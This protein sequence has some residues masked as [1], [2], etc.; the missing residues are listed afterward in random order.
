MLSSRKV[1]IEVRLARFWPS[2]F[3]QHAGIRRYMDVRNMSFAIVRLVD[4]WS[5]G[6][7]EHPERVEKHPERAEL[8]NDALKPVEEMRRIL[9]LHPTCEKSK[10]KEE[11]DMVLDWVRNLSPELFRDPIVVDRLSD[12]LCAKWGNKE[13]LTVASSDFCNRLL[14]SVTYTKDATALVKFLKKSPNLGDKKQFLARQFEQWKAPSGTKIPEIVG[15]LHPLLATVAAKAEDLITLLHA[16]DKCKKERLNIEGEVESLF[17]ELLSKETPFEAVKLLTGC[18]FCTSHRLPKNECVEADETVW[19]GLHRDALVAESDMKSFDDDAFPAVGAESRELPGD[20]TLFQVF[21]KFGENLFAQF[22]RTA[23]PAQLVEV[24]C[25]SDVFWKLCRPLMTGWTLEGDCP[26]GQED[27]LVSIIEKCPELFDTLAP[28]VWAAPVDEVSTKRVT[29]LLQQHSANVLDVLPMTWWP[30]LNFSS[31]DEKKL[32]RVL[33]AGIEVQPKTVNF[34]K[35][36]SEVQ[37]LLLQQHWAS[38]EVL[39]DYAPQAVFNITACLQRFFELLTAKE[40]ELRELGDGIDD[41]ERL[42]SG[43]NKMVHRLLLAVRERIKEANFLHTDEQLVIFSG[44][45]GRL[46]NSNS[47]LL[48]DFME[49]KAVDS[50]HLER[51]VNLVLGSRKFANIT[52]DSA[53]RAMARLTPDER[54]ALHKRLL[55][56]TNTLPVQVIFSLSVSVLHKQSVPLVIKQLDT[57]SSDA[58]EELLGLIRDANPKVGNVHTFPRNL[59]ATFRERFLERYL[60]DAHSKRDQRLFK[61]FVACTDT[62]A[63]PGKIIEVLSRQLHPLDDLFIDALSFRASSEDVHLGIEV[64]NTPMSA[65]HFQDL[66]EFFAP[67]EWTS[68]LDWMLKRVND[69][70]EPHVLMEHLLNLLDNKAF[71]MVANKLLTMIIKWSGPKQLRGVL[72][73]DDRIRSS[74][75][76]AVAKRTTKTDRTLWIEFWQASWERGVPA[77]DQR[78]QEVISAIDLTRN[79]LKRQEVQDLGVDHHARKLLVEMAPDTA[80]PVHGFAIVK[81]EPGFAASLSDDQFKQ[82]CSVN[83]LDAKSDTRWPLFRTIIPQVEPDRGLTLAIDLLNASKEE[84]DVA[85]VKRCFQSADRFTRKQTKLQAKILPRLWQKYSKELQEKVI[86]ETWRATART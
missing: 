56:T 14:Q 31:L 4:R 60:Q 59:R 7:A 2:K 38:Y 29:R 69:S 21:G 37:E 36:D 84:K 5:F 50:L 45:E 49:S 11:W 64:Q 18:S 24:I 63:I 48:A 34:H 17:F 71:T 40:G 42:K 82:I 85:L 46:D 27:A 25:N 23:D 78:R 41:V 66:I 1:E 13:Q 3:V 28:K 47:S 77:K 20:R 35:L 10:T 62:D 51:V 57:L 39:A 26:A 68:R 67:E 79:P 22:L 76:M 86:D 43:W 53:L 19:T 72:L 83:Q 74:L 33:K 73:A 15:Y 44:C 61:L 58:W 54:D 32:T 52:R 8:I 70:P 12:I 16:F 65:S 81:E 55:D 6:K 30:S 80:V 75:Q 9:H